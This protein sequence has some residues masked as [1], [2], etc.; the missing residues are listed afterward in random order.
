MVIGDSEYQWAQN[1]QLPS[2]PLG[3]RTPRPTQSGSLRNSALL[4]LVITLRACL[5]LGGRDHLNL[6]HGRLCSRLRGRRVSQAA[7]HCRSNLGSA[8]LLG[9]LR[10]PL[11][12]PLFK[13]RR[14][15]AHCLSLPSAPTIWA[16]EVALKSHPWGWPSGSLTLRH[17]ASRYSINPPLSRCRRISSVFCRFW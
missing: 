4:C 12:D 3:S 6:C 7:T 2:P 5:G 16:A 14:P 17:P 13:R 15:T 1:T 8:N 11:H 10:P 9:V